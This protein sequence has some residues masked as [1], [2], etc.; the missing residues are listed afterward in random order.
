[1]R[2]KEADGGEEGAEP[3]GFR[4]VEVET[5]AAGHKDPR[6]GY[7]EFEFR[8][9][10]RQQQLSPGSGFIREVGGR[11]G[12]PFRTEK[13]LSETS[14]GDEGKLATQNYAV[15]KEHPGLDRGPPSGRSSGEQPPAKQLHRPY[16]S[17][18]SSTSFPSQALN[19]Y[20]STNV[21]SSPGSIPL[22]HKSPVNLSPYAPPAFRP[23]KQ[24][25]TAAAGP[26]FA[27]YLSKPINP[28]VKPVSS[29]PGRALQPPLQAASR[30]AAP[31]LQ[32]ISGSQSHNPGVFN[33]FV[34][35]PDTPS[36]NSAV[37][38]P[39]YA[40]QG[41]HPSKHPGFSDESKPLQEAS[42]MP[43][44]F[45]RHG[46]GSAKSDDRTVMP[47]GGTARDMTDGPAVPV[48][49]PLG[50]PAPPRA[51]E[52][53]PD[54]KGRLVAV[55]QPIKSEESDISKLNAVKT[56]VKEE[57]P[58]IRAGAPWFPGMPGPQFRVEP[59][60]DV[61][62]MTGQELG[63]PGIQL[64]GVVLQ[65]TEGGLLVVNVSYRGKDFM[66]TLMDTSSS[67]PHN[68]WASPRLSDIPAPDKRPKKKKSK[69][70]TA[71]EL[72]ARASLRSRRTATRRQKKGKKRKYKETENGT[73]R[74]E[75]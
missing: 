26:N 16:S 32:T 25:P 59:R 53:G 70:E 63:G 13:R 46:I 65:E 60:R 2:L 58:D 10:K 67:S 4:K 69:G 19:P 75:N 64:E 52:F 21:M 39:K 36:R 18:A 74:R 15:M 45:S 56:E 3:A 72:S 41:L 54:N 48:R 42:S 8:E 28:A 11:A 47:Q 27:P 7:T 68:H 20:S 6:R 33:P 1:M 51:H 73:R 34:G 38:T 23:N 17:S 12:V 29:N 31:G 30:Q 55:K 35:T 61:S 43:M 50:L 5:A 71:I 22:G 9:E 44:N 49:I 40:Q 57:T 62:T 66:G 24:T 14:G 37:T